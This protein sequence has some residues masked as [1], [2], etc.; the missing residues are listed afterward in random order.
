MIIGYLLIIGFSQNTMKITNGIMKK[1]TPYIDDKHPTTEELITNDGLIKNSQIEY[2]MKEKEEL[3]TAK[4]ESR[5][6]EED[7]LTAAKL[8]IKDLEKT[9]II[10]LKVQHGKF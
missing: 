2:N 10:L 9:I 7:K 3:T 6:K 4:D 5:L 1:N 8:Y